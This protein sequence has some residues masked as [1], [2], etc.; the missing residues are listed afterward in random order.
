MQMKR[1]RHRRGYDFEIIKVPREMF[2][3]GRRRT[4]KMLTYQGDRLRLADLLANAYLQGI[5]DGY[6]TAEHTRPDAGPEVP[7]QCSHA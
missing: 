2:E 6:K 5:E 1:E 4:E 7:A 3:L